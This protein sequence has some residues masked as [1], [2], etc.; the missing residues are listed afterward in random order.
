MNAKTS[1]GSDSPRRLIKDTPHETDARQLLTSYTQ[2]VERLS[3]AEP[4]LRHLMVG[5]LYHLVAL[6]RG[7]T[8]DAPQ[9]RNSRS[10]QA[11]RLE[12]IK[13]EILDGLD[14]HELSL[15]GLAARHGVTPRYVQR[16]FE[17]EGFTFSQFVRDHRLERAYRMLSDRRFAQCTISTIAYDAGFGDLSHFNRAFRRRFGK[18]PSEARAAAP[19][20]EQPLSQIDQTGSVEHHP[21]P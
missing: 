1:G 3:V 7:A 15:A 9:S 21:C 5:H 11:A 19:W 10:G 16:L 4:E 8:R 13:T 20:N 17:S 18:S 14:R 12:A 2:V 6:V